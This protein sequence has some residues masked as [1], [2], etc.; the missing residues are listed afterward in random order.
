MQFRRASRFVAALAAGALGLT[1]CSADDAGGAGADPAEGSDATAGASALADVPEGG[2][3]SIVSLSPTATEVLFAIGAGDRV[4]AVDEYSYYPPEAPVVEG[5]SGFELDNAESVLTFDP[6]LVIVSTAPPGLDEQLES[7]GVEL[8]VLPAAATLDD[9][10]SQVEQLGAATDEIGGAAEVVKDM[11]TGIEE[12]VASVPQEIRDSRLTYYHE[13]SPDL[14]SITDATFL[15][16]IYGLFGMSSIASGAADGSDGGYPRLNPEAVVDAN[17]PF[18]FLADAGSA[19]VT[20]ADVAARPGWDEISA[21]RDGS[22]FPLDE[23]LAARWGPRLPQ[24][25]QSI[26]DALNRATLPAGAPA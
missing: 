4:K 3:D 15:G 24:F 6:D 19:G 17:P 7:A 20:A 21:V 10:Y 9:A 5:L 16:E 18:I 22:V 13:V 1:A 11:R 14:H 12:A 23:D 2:Y 8:M 26:A 25:V